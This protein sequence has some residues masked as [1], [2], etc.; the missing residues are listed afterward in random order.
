MFSS[1]GESLFI[2]PLCYH[3]TTVL[4][5]DDDEAF[6]R[7][8][9]LSVENKISLLSFSKPELAID[10][11]KNKHQY[12]PFLSR[13]LIQENNTVM[14]DF[15]SLRNEIYNPD[16]FKEI[17][18]NVTD[19]DM[20]HTSGIELIKT[21][22]SPAA[23]ELSHIIL[24]G[25]ISG[26]F[27]EKIAKMNMSDRYIGKDDPDYIN[28]L[29]DMIEKKSE[30]I[31]QSRSYEPA[32]ILSRNKKENTSFLF[33]GNFAPIFNEYIK[34]NSICEF[35]LFDQQG[36]YIFLDDEANLRWLF[37]RNESGIENSIELAA[38]Y[39]A[40]QHVIDALKTKKVIL[41][42][43][44][45]EDFEKRTNIDWSEYLLPATVFES[46]DEFLSFFPGLISDSDKEKNIL[47]KYYYSFAKEF[48][49]Q[50]IDKEKI[51]SYRTFLSEQD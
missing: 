3:P 18:I 7:M 23:R 39:G 33:D 10:Y 51:L 42:L 46:N 11:A 19:Y 44:E 24:T 9:S 22:E 30:K 26:E 29:L 47:P 37:V 41:S 8:L 28:K 12:V 17:V 35:Y 31:F 45:K 5:V 13:C 4:S 34:E 38:Q 49:E 48:P 16:R 43:Y 1:L 40:P 36:S 14:F 32:R 20:P 21:M 15:M 2:L 6:S 27:K 50:G 25:K